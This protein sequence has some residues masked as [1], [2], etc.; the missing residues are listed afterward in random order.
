VRGLAGNSRDW[1]GNIWRWEGPRVAR[2][3]LVLEPAGPDDPDFHAVRGGAWSSA[4]SCSR[5]A[6][7]FGN[8]P[9]LRRASTGIRLA[10]S[11]IT[12]TG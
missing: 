12:W 7:R 6:T 10:R 9:T 2:D 4:L 1:C 3:R 11:L 5:A 8:R